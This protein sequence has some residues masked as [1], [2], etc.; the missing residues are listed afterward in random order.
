MH[1]NTKYLWTP[2][3]S[4]G[5]SMQPRG[6]I[7][8]S[9]VLIIPVLCVMTWRIACYSFSGHSI[10]HA[11]A[12]WNLKL[13]LRLWAQGQHASRIARSGNS[14]FSLKE[15]SKTQTDLRQ[16]GVSSSSL[17]VSLSESRK[18]RRLGQAEPCP[19][20]FFTLK[21]KSDLCRLGPSRALASKHYTLFQVSRKS[22]DMVKALHM[23]YR[24]VFHSLR[25]T[26]PGR[27]SSRTGQIGP[28]HLVCTH[29][30]PRP[31]CQPV[32]TYPNGTRRVTDDTDRDV[33]PTVLFWAPTGATHVRGRARV[34]AA[35]DYQ[36]SW[37]F[38]VT[39]GTKSDCS[40]DDVAIQ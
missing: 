9:Q 38:M 12:L 29:E 37:L 4:L 25:L 18:S 5:K 31:L 32:A 7:W 28:H 22:I 14:T 6:H 16:T 10:I 21:L 11:N 24:E 36:S 39:N 40:V 35:I 27:G 8:T 1:M 23:A 20:W 26:V 30:D 3:N 17:W 34:I 19:L 15:D 13:L 2:P 33:R